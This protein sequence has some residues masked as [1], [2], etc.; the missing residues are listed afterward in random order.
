MPSR[1]H[2]EKTI[3]SL[4][5]KDAFLTPDTS[6]R[7]Y[8]NA[9]RTLPLHWENFRGEIVTVVHN[10]G[11]RSTPF[12]R[13]ANYPSCIAWGNGYYSPKEVKRI[14]GKKF[15][16]LSCKSLFT[17]QE[18]K[19]NYFFSTVFAWPTFDNMLLGNLPDKA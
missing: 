9:L 15:I 3:T 12:L 14:S 17:K 5:E 13:S 11:N 6:G 7:G 16:C 18:I 19:K 2:R 1:Q 10:N 4:C 8:T